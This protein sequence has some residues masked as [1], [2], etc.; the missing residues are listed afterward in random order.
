MIFEDVQT[1]FASCHNK[2]YQ[3]FLLEEMVT[4]W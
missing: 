2:S 1:I 3:V 4:I